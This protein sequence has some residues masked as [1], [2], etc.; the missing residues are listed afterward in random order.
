MSDDALQAASEFSTKFQ[1]DISADAAAYFHALIL[2]GQTKEAV[3]AL[4]QSLNLPDPDKKLAK[5]L[6]QDVLT[7]LPHGAVQTYFDVL[8]VDQKKDPGTLQLFA[9]YLAAPPTDAPTITAFLS[10]GATDTAQAVAQVAQTSVV[11]TNAE[12]AF[13]AFIE[14]RLDAGSAAE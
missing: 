3:Q 7:T 9:D 4:S 11:F 2:A 1:P 6:L 14:K 12:E 8:S 5:T 10:V 13:Q